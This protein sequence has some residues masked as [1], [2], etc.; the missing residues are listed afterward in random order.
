[1][2]IILTTTGVAGDLFP[3]IPVA[4]ELAR[5]GHQ[6]SFCANPSFR[7]TIEA[8]GFVFRDHAKAGGERLAADEIEA[9]YLT[10]PRA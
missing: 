7:E 3:M 1:M 5:R 9:T 8:A 6:V 2:K 4:L 10:N